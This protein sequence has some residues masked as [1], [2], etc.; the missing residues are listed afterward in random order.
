MPSDYTPKT[1]PHQ[2]RLISLPSP[3]RA[4]IRTW[5]RTFLPAAAEFQ[6]PRVARIRGI[7]PERLRSSLSEDMENGQ[8]GFLGERRVNVLELNLALDRL[9]K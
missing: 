8:F 3:H 5:I 7:D 1:R 9:S 2:F 4:W 6:I